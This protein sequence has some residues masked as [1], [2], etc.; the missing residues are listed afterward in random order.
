MKIDTNDILNSIL[1]SLT[2]I[3]YIRAEEIPNI[4]LYMDQVTT[5]MDEQ[6]A[7]TKR[8]D[9]DKILTKTMINNYAKNH[10]LP[11]PVKKKYSREHVLILI[12]I[13]YFKNILSI[14]DIETVLKPLTE[15]YFS[16]ES[17]M[18][19]ASI[20]REICE[21]EQDRVEPLKE[22]VK[23][24][25]EKSMSAFSD[26]PDGEERDELKLFAFICSLC[27][28]VYLKK[29]MIEKL[30]DELEEKKKENKKEKN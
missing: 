22:T 10:L 5:F 9:D 7:S 8:Y 28:D 2:N 16:G 23:T 3:D 11:P 12:F 27:F 24:A 26:L 14:K 25:Y 15:K 13:Y 18:D 6:L 29:E 4:N 1:D 21:I 30:I 20:Y 19:L 17:S